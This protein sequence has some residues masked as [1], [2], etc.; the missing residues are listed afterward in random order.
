MKIKFSLSFHLAHLR[1][2]R[3]GSGAQAVG[4]FYFRKKLQTGVARFCAGETLCRE[5]RV[6]IV[7]VIKF[8]LPWVGG[9][10]AL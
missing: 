10:L 1:E 8:L 9:G 5:L 2:G 3:T 4:K 7:R 6:G